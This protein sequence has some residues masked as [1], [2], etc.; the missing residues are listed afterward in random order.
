MENLD[1]AKR[2]EAGV[3][4]Q[5]CPTLRQW[6]ELL[7]FTSV[8]HWM[9]VTL[10]KGMRSWRRWSSSAE[11]HSWSG[12]TAVGGRQCSQQLERSSDIL[13]LASISPR[14]PIIKHSGIW[15][16]QLLNIVLTEN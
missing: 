15:L 7:Y 14:E 8:T 13:E 10:R 4:F 1:S 11:S 2:S 3:F 12:M 16:S 6:S 9:K 5:T